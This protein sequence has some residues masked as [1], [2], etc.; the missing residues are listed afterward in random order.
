MCLIRFVSVFLA[1]TLIFFLTTGC[2]PSGK[3]YYNHDEHWSD[4]CNWISDVRL[5]IMHSDCEIAC[6]DIM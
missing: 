2:C 5:A 4:T 6:I 3:V 1:L